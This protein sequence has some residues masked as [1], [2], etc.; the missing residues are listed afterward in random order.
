MN[1]NNV[2]VTGL[3]YWL[4][5]YDLLLDETAKILQCNF[6]NNSLTKNLPMDKIVKILQY[7]F[8]KKKFLTENV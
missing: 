1:N 4:T 6:L 5:P 2:G 3:Q 8:G 7:H